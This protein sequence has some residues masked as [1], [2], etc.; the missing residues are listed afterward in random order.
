MSANCLQI[1][2]TR[3]ARSLDGQDS[4]TV[5]PATTDATPAVAD[6]S[7]EPALQLNNKSHTGLHANTRNRELSATFSQAP[8]QALTPRP[9]MWVG[10]WERETYVCNKHHYN[11][12]YVIQKAC[13]H[14]VVINKR[15]SYRPTDSQNDTTIMWSVTALCNTKW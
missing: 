4:T 10:Y 8:Y 13:M 1:L 14:T 11:T 5:I 6:S 2:A 7:A 12:G 9:Q 3:Q 15:Q